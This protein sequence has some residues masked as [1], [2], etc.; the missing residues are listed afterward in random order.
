MA[1]TAAVP[2]GDDMRDL[3]LAGLLA[4]LVFAAC[5]EDAEG[6]RPAVSAV[7][8]EA[9]RVAAPLQPEGAWTATEVRARELTAFRAG[10][11]RPEGLEGGAPS[12][13]KLVA[14][15]V[16]ALEV[17]DTAAFAPLLLS[18]AEFAWLYYD[19]HPLSRP[20]YDLSPDEMWFKQQGNSAKGLREVL[21]K[22]G[23]RP[24]GFVGFRCDPVVSFGEN[25][26]HGNC[27]VERRGDGA[28]DAGLVRERL[29]GALVE[30]A[31]RWKFV[32]YSA[33]L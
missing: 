26:F 2:N 30:R 21:E 6:T 17:R 25:R 11:A 19:A 16:R 7:H 29:F 12:A 23:G 14:A 18:R 4:L 9:A 15:W 32:S 20:P 3:F 27:V 31:G 10:L 13:R 5:G 28:A 22:R 1:P 24:L 8:A 33:R